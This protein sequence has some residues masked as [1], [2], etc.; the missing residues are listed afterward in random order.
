[1]TTTTFTPK[2]KQTRKQLAELIRTILGGVKPTYLGA[3]S[4]AYQIGG[5]ELDRNWQVAW[6]VDLPKRDVEMI[7][8]LAAQEGY[9]IARETETEESAARQREGDAGLQR[10]PDQKGA[11]PP[12]FTGRGRQG[13]DFLPLVPPNTHP[14]S[15][16][17]HH[18]A[19]GRDGKDRKRRE[20]GLTQTASGRE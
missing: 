17:C 11:W 18:T 14:G 20:K 6:P 3:P 10:P 9:D 12:R 4:M 8:T 13:R 7:E 15:C 1:M 16:G 2:G 5:I 19:T